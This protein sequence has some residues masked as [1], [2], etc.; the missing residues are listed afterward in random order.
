MGKSTDTFFDKKKA[1]SI[2][3]DELL[4]CYLRPYMQKLFQTGKM[5]VYIDCF[6]GAGKFGEQP[7]ELIDIK[8]DDIP[9]S[10]GSPLIALKEIQR[11]YESSRAQ[12][13]R[14]VM[15]CIEKKYYKPLK[16]NIERSQ[17]SRMNYQ[18]IEGSYQ[19]QVPNVMNEVTQ[20][21]KKPNLFCYLDPYG[22]KDLRIS[23]LKKIM[24]YEL[25]N[26]E[27]L[28]NF[29]SFGFFRYACAT[30]DIA[31]RESDIRRSEEVIEQDPL[32]FLGG[33]H[34]KLSIF[35]EILGTDAW[36]RV[37]RT[38]RRGEIDGYKAERIV[39]GFYKKQLKR[40][41]GFKYVLSI[42]IRLNESLHPKYRMVYATNHEHGAALMGQVMLTRQKYLYEQ[43]S[44]A[45]NGGL[46]LFDMEDLKQNR[47][48]RECVLECLEGEDEMGEKSFKAKFYDCYFLSSKIGET[49]KT[50]EAEGKILIRRIPER[51][52]KNK[53]SKFMTESGRNR[54]YIK[55]NK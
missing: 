39:S 36:I 2:A 53:P 27:L 6:A 25:N 30:S 31:I 35:G 1:W 14:Y 55:L 49:L 37:I 21:Y 54:M 41:L 33:T 24:N 48:L 20:R 32:L 16:E 40:N 47:T 15:Y 18:V 42:P 5:I 13:P 51:T 26:Q 45:S 52:P 44:L 4:R 7:L 29:N 8:M 3:K 38:Y 34:E 12:N 11:S 50:L 10:Y 23:Y 19:E 22:V 17:F 43:S 46:S 9:L 28:I